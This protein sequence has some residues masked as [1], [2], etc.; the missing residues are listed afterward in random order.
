MVSRA[1]PPVDFAHHWPDP[2]SV[3]LIVACSE[4][5]ACCFHLQ[6]LVGTSVMS[7]STYNVIFLQKK[8]PQAQIFSI[9][10]FPKPPV[11]SSVMGIGQNNPCS[12]RLSCMTTQSFLP[13]PREKTS[14]P[15]EPGLPADP[16]LSI[17]LPLSCKSLRARS[18][19]VRMVRV[20]QVSFN[21]EDSKAPN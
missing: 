7:S 13:M 14:L 18:F 10:P 15:A 6:I 16:V 11:F 1:V 12:F 8:F 4:R 19:M 17:P 3:D 21:K 5:E 2:S 20:T 9:F